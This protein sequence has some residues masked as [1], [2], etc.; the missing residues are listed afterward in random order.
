M[1]CTGSGGPLTQCCTDLLELNG[2][3]FR[4]LPLATARRSWHGYWD[5]CHPPSRSDRADGPMRAIEV[6]GRMEGHH[7]LERDMWALDDLGT[8]TCA[9]L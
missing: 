6:R 3:D 2:K 8:Q 9:V 5:G 1:R 4:P 7:A